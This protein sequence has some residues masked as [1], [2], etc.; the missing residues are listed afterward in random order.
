MSTSSSSVLHL[1]TVDPGHTGSIH[2]IR[3]NSSGT[4]T[5]SGGQDR[6]IQLTNIDTGA[7]VKSYQLH[8]YEV[9]GLCIASDSSM[10][11]VSHFMTSQEREINYNLESVCKLWWRQSRLSVGR[12]LWKYASKI[13]RPPVSCQLRGV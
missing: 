8:A 7:R 12:L 10:V 11:C 3:L 6:K 13:Q 4:Y 2:T 5:L 9:V 1:R